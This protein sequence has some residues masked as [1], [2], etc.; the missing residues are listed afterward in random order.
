MADPATAAVFDPQGVLRDVPQSMLADAVKAGG[1]PAVRFQAPDKS[2]RYVPANRTQEAQA[3]G[4]K[5]LPF[6]QQDVKHPGFWSTLYGDAKGIAGGVAST[7]SAASSAMAGNPGPMAAQS[8]DTA[9]KVLDNMQHRRD[10]GRSL[11]YRTVAPV[12]DVI[13]VN[14]RGMED[15]ADQGDRAAIMAHATAAAAPAAAGAAAS[16]LTPFASR[17]AESLSIPSDSFVAR[18]VRATAH[19]A[20]T[21]L[22]K[23]P[24][25]VG[26]A[27]GSA[28]GRATGI[29]GAIK[30]GGAAGYALGKEILPQ[31]RIPGEGFGL[32]SRVIG[33]PKTIPPEAA[34]AATPGEAGTMAESVAAP[35]AAA[36]SEAEPAA[37]T[38]ENVPRRTT[39]SGESALKEVLSRLPNKTQLQIARSRGINVTAEA[40]LKATPAVTERIINKIVD[41]YSDDELD[42]VR[43]TYVEN[44][45]RFGQHSFVGD[46]GKEANQTLNLQTYFPEL[47]I[48]LAQQLRTQKAIQAANA[49]KYAPLSNLD[50]SI[51]AA[52]TKSSSAPK[53]AASAAS[54][55]LLDLVNASVAK[56]ARDKASAQ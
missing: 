27:A 49:N 39:I 10:E 3:A 55:N 8:A 42:G 6:E 37:G 35:K 44:E 28:I 51:K 56:V 12:G 31:V 54:D 41:D 43:S 25:S 5:I 34:A 40:Q 9:Q 16:E 50:A 52:A 46:V 47:K 30:I 36:A 7:L 23:A 18:A 14:T 24:G 45:G 32:P 26:T 15:A 4:G 1:M 38:V 13:G 22:E 21:V 33:G 11:A 19:G 48:P 29:P 53:P 20:N 2:I 17:M